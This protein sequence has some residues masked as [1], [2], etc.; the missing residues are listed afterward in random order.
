MTSITTIGAYFL[1][2]VK[3][4]QSSDQEAVEALLAAVKKQE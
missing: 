4:L 1:E 2:D 3:S